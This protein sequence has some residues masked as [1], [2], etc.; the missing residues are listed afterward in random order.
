M[1]SMLTRL[2][3]LY[4]STRFFCI[5]FSMGA[6]IIT[7]LLAKMS[8]EFARRVIAGL[9]VAQGYCA[10]SLRLW[11]ATSMVAFDES[12]TRRILGYENAEEFYRDISSVS[13]IPKITVPLV[14]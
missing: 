7:R 6:N 14:S 2:A 8:P 10:A 1:E 4:P 3:D 13:L 11:A 9:S 5:G 12:Y